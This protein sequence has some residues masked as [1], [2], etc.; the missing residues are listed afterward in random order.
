MINRSGHWDWHHLR[1]LK[2]EMMLIGVDAHHWMGMLAHSHRDA[3]VQ[4][5]WSVLHLRRCRRHHLDG[6]LRHLWGHRHFD[7]GWLGRHHWMDG[8]NRT[9]CHIHFLHVGLIWKIEIISHRILFFAQKSQKFDFCAKIQ[10]LIKIWFLR[11]SIVV[12]Y[13]S[14]FLNVHPY[15]T[16]FPY[17]L[18]FLKIIFF[19]QNF[20]FYTYH[21]VG[22][23]HSN[24]R[25]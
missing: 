16:S 9:G 5:R 17:K 6:V 14:L 4:L 2:M 20:H 7:V 21:K 24:F 10:F 23:V 22:Y 15:Q 19:S 11:K 3:V 13:H 12:S 8:H 1:M 25:H 18:H